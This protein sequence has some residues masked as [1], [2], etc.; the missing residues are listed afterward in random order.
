VAA[1]TVVLVAGPT[2]AYGL[3]AHRGGPPPSGPTTPPDVPVAACTVSTLAPPPGL[4]GF[5]QVQYATGDGTGRYVVATLQKWTGTA[6][7]VRTVRWRDGRPEVL[8]IPNSSDWVDAVNAAGTV[9]GG[10]LY[11]TG[12]GWIV[13][14]DTYSLLPRHG[15]DIM[16]PTAID[17]AGNIV[18]LGQDRY[19]VFDG[20]ALWPAD[21][22][23]TVRLLGGPSGA[24]P[25][26]IDD[27]G[28]VVGQSQDRPFAWLQGRVGPL[29]TDPARP[30]GAAM[31]VRGAWAVGYVGP[32]GPKDQSTPMGAIWR[33]DSGAPPTVIAATAMLSAVAAN[34]TAVGQLLQNATADGPVIYRAG[35]LARLPM[36]N[37]QAS[38]EVLANAVSIT[39][40]GATIVGYS[41][42]SVYVWRC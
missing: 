28:T 14:G 42:E 34:G 15:D 31:A 3:T 22:P 23:G 9:I 33:L 39:D 30:L 40:D 12:G 38:D 19:G 1:A 11:S 17:A 27:R 32:D 26:A 18:G 16:S 2:L 21:Q 10:G 6:F 13:R 7:A 20:A 37:G 25:T 8:P 41:S 36:P 4:A 5:Y 29:P 35:V 24:Q